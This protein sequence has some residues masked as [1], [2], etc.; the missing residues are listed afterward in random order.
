MDLA[1]A[2]WGLQTNSAAVSASVAQAVPPTT[3]MPVSG[4]VTI[5]V[6]PSVKTEIPITAPYVDVNVQGYFQ[7]MPLNF[8]FFFTLHF[9]K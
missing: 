9:V 1:R 2:S 4:T 5:V 8:V 6:E 3:E 7:Y